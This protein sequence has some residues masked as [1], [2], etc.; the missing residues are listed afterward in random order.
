MGFLVQ[1]LACPKE[2]RTGLEGVYELGRRNV[3]TI[4]TTFNQLPD[5]LEL[6]RKLGKD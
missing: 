4:L 2:E 6:F 5:S 1:L 3:W